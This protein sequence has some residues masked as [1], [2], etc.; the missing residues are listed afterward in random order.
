MIN[1]PVAFCL[2]T[3]SLLHGAFPLL[4]I[5]SGQQRVTQKCRSS[6][7]SSSTSNWDDNNYRKLQ[8]MQETQT[9]SKLV[10]TLIVSGSSSSLLPIYVRGQGKLPLS[11]SKKNATQLVLFLTR[12]EQVESTTSSLILPLANS[13]Q[14]KLISFAAAKRPLSKSVL[15]GLN[16]LLVNRDNALFDN[17]PWSA[18]SKDPQMRNRDAAGNSIN[19]KF[20]LGKRDAYNRFIGKDWQGRSVAIGNM[21]LRLK[22]MLEDTLQDDN[23]T[24]DDG[25]DDDEN[26]KSLAQRILQLQIRELQ[27]ELAEIESQM[28]ISRNDINESQRS[29]EEQAQKRQELVESQLRL[30]EL[31]KV[32]E[33]PTSIVSDVLN[34]IVEWS[35]LDGQ[36]AAPYR[37]AM[38][39]APMLDSKQDIEES[40]LP[41]TSPYDF[42][43]EILKDQLNAKVIGCVLE[44]TSLLR[45]NLAVGGVVILQRIVAKETVKVLGESITVNKPEEEF[46]NDGV[47]GGEMMV[48]ECDADEAIGLALTYNIPLKVESE[49]LERATAMAE[50]SNTNVVKD[51]NIWN[52]LPVWVQM[53]KELS[54]GVEGVNQ[55]AR[56]TSP[57]SIPRTTAS[58][59][60][61]IFESKPDNSP[62]F[63]TDNPIVSLG[64]F[65]ALSNEDKAKTLLEMSN[66]RGR[67]PRPRVVRNA[68]DNPLDELL[69]P[70]IDESVRRQYLIRNAERSGDT[71]RVEELKSA[72]SKYQA[73]KEKAEAA[74]ESGSDDATGKWESEAEFLETLRADVT[75][76]EGSYSRFLDRDEWY[77]RNRQATAKRVKKSSFGTLLDGIE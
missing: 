50:P 15:L 54:L 21:A 49:V 6:L 7:A 23:D 35:T 10:D 34:K 4:S 42:L 31:S 62:L 22:Y 1:P 32:P 45:G 37:G 25:V 63:P 39:Y 28:T 56:N 60:D 71:A 9:H 66:F 41:Y 61:S 74:R 53:D 19:E 69:L 48:V 3:L 20:H 36:N 11:S 59:F 27:M 47:P 73:A 12:E 77:E 29:A 55:T 72:K 70:L 24:N 51:E 67:L 52:V 76:D 68:K 26:R 5:R 17:L 58:L 75:Q 38:G 33:T 18:W 30:E 65:D 14:L 2:V 40:L 43:K 64:E 57:I 16:T 13:N 44:N 8:Q 46:G